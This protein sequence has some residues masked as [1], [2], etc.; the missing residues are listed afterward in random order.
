MSSPILDTE[1]TDKQEQ[2]L[3]TKLF[4]TLRMFLAPVLY[5]L[6]HVVVA[7]GVDVVEAGDGAGDAEDLVVGARAEVKCLVVCP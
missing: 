3:F 7:D 2:P 1:T 5:R 6:A 4:L